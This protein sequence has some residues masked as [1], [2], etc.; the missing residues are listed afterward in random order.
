MGW[1]AG[2]GSPVAKAAT[3]ATNAEFDHQR[4]HSTTN[5]G[6]PVI[7]DTTPIVV[8][9]TVASLAVQTL[10]LQTSDSGG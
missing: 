10:D 5:I 6:G 1:A 3:L 2:A 7:E 8:T 4:Y 9:I